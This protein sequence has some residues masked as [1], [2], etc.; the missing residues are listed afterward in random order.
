MPL[1][2]RGHLRIT[3]GVEATL[4]IKSYGERRI[5]MKMKQVSTRLL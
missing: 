3:F 5:R 4:E 2:F 1:T